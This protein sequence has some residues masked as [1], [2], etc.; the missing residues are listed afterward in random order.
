MNTTQTDNGKKQETAKDILTKN[1]LQ[2]NEGI[3]R[4]ESITVWE[5]NSRKV[6]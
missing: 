1:H 5:G 6:W 4:S 3:N 2:W